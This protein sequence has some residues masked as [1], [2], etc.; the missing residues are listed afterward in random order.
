MTEIRYDGPDVEADTSGRVQGLTMVT[1]MTA[2]GIQAG[3]AARAG[4][5]TQDQELA[6]R[7][8]GEADRALWSSVPPDQLHTLTDQ[9]LAQRWQAT[10]RHPGDPD[11]HTTRSS[12]ESVLAERD[13]ETMR[14]YRSWLA[15]GVPPGRAMSR[16]LAERDTRVKPVWTPLTGGGAHAL[17]P[18]TL[19]TAWT[20]ALVS[21]DPGAAPAVAAG[22]AALRTQVPDLMAAYDTAR[23]RGLDPHEAAAAVTG[24]PLAFGPNPTWTHIRQHGV[25]PATPVTRTAIPTTAGATP[26][27]APRALLATARPGPHR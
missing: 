19:A 22:E 18:S 1:I 16:A 24:A 15:T 8:A 11:A 23:D 25:P 4:R 5:A 7:E 10:A 27:P 6:V 3:R 14:D 2:E 21:H 13:P 12:L 9:Q 20:A 17:D 26:T